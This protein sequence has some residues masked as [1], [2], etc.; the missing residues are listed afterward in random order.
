MVVG[1]SSLLHAGYHH[2]ATRPWQ[3]ERAITKSALIY[4]IFISDNPDD[5]YEIKSMPE[6]YRWGVNRLEEFLSPLV[7]KG[8]RSVMLFGVVKPESKDP[9]AS[10]ADTEKNPVIQAIGIIKYKFP[11]LHIGCDVCLCDYTS[12]GHCGVLFEDGTINNP[13]SVKR[14]VELAVAYAKAG[15]DCVAPSDMM[16]GRMKAIKE[17][18]L[19]AN[20]SHRVSLMAYS[21]KFASGMYG[22]FRDACDSAPTFGDR[23]CYQLPP[24]ARGLARRALAR[25][26]NEGADFLMVK[27]ALPYL[28]IIRDAK[29]D[30]PNHPIACYQ[31]SGEYSMIWRSAEA[32]VLDLKRM[33]FETLESMLRAGATV[34]LTYYTPR[35]LEWLDELDQ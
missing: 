8:L 10:I 30:F 6:Q 26:A 33:V 22:P 18:L 25:D 15:A 19:A 28:D 35:M 17:G 1:T 2:P 11:S 7:K 24:N 27:P 14:L 16:D 20:L 5:K 34:I 12:H 32:G 23:R 9:T 13:E 4:P 3:S 29:E 21:A 31:V